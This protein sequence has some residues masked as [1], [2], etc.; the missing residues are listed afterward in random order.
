[1]VDRKSLLDTTRESVDDDHPSVARGPRFAAILTVLRGENPGVMYTLEGSEALVGRSPEVAV[2]VPDDTLSRRHAYIRRIGNV[3][4]I[5]DLES[6]NGTFVDGIRVEGT[7][8][9]ED[10][11]RIGVGARTVLHFRMVDAVELEAARQTYALTVLDPLTGVFNRR[12]LQERLAAETAYATRHGTPLSL[13]LLDIDHFKQINDA[14]GH[15][16]GDEA[17]CM[18]A[19][20]LGKLAR[21]EDVLARFGGE[22]FALITRGID[23][24]GAFALAERARAAV[25]EQCLATETGTIRFTVSI[26]I[27]QC[28]AGAGSA[29]QRMF[30]AADR[31]LY[32]AKDSGRN[33]VSI[34]PQAG[35][36]GEQRGNS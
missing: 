34:A 13:L 17:L 18:L 15:A 22:E 1:V 14:H 20:L 36:T 16:A 19:K 29:A 2:T 33:C 30:E 26:G 3:F 11:C 6:T 24:Q 5:Q 31:A 9:L 21:R 35:L 23:Q 25:A 8:A 12:H 4:A 10:G 28:E 27:A 32:A 7:Q